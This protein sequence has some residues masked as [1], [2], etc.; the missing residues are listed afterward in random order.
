M[1]EADYRPSS[2]CSYCGTILKKYLT[3]FEVEYEISL[4][5]P[6]GARDLGLK[7]TERKSTYGPSYYSCPE[8][9]A[10]YGIKDEHLYDEDL[11]LVEEIPDKNTLLNEF[12]KKEVPRSARILKAEA[13][14][15]LRPDYR[16]SQYGDCFIATSVYGSP[17][18]LEVRI[19]RKFRDEYL[20]K[21]LIGKIFVSFYYYFSP[22]LVKYLENKKKIKIFIKKVILDPLATFISNINK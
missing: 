16:I 12:I 5:P 19:L 14:R 13:E 7:R 20:L 3:K 21:S 22:S 11:Y 1:G 2:N 17:D 10:K 9:G 15:S 8:C 18:T 6:P 4:T